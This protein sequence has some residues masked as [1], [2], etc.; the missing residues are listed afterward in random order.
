MR[1]L[2]LREIAETVELHE[3]TISRV[4][5][6]KYMMTPRGI[7]ELKYFFGSHVSTD[8]GGACSATAIR[9]LIKQLVAY[10]KRKKTFIRRTDCR[11]ARPARHCGGTPH[12][13]QV[14]RIAANLARQSAQVAVMAIIGRNHQKGTP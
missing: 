12:H 9:A 14:P 13:C 5:T 1:P 8:A 6:Q 3:S 11:V 10:R 7:Y 2:V 4:T